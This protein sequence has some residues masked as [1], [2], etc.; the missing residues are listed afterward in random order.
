MEAAAPY[1][2][3]RPGLPIFQNA[4]VGVEAAHISGNPERD[5]GYGSIPYVQIVLKRFF[6]N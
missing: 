6:A 2:D 3:S 4:A 5:G 1:V